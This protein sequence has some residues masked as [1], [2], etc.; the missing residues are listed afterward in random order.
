MRLGLLS[1]SLVAACVTTQGL[2]AQD[3]PPRQGSFARV[4]LGFGA[5]RNRDSYGTGRDARG[6]VASVHA[7]GGGRRVQ[8][9][10]QLDW[11]PF[12]VE[13][14][15]RDEDVSFVYAID[16]VQFFL[17]RHVY[18]RPGLGLALARWSSPAEV[19]REGSYLA[20]ALALGAEWRVVGARWLS[21]ELSWR[22]ASGLCFETCSFAA[23]RLLGLQA[24]V[25]FY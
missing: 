3:E 15:F 17:D 7:G 20:A 6:L 9:V 13:V 14:P 10:L 23:T 25:P 11:Q 16:A 2:M 12:P 24:L 19:R 18:L 22:G 4:G 21:F 1:L 5:A 8:A